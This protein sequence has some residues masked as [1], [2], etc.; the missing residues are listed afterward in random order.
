MFSNA[1]WRFLTQ[2][3]WCEDNPRHHYYNITWVG[4]A[5]EF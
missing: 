3:K 2:L 4:L 5:M 1:L